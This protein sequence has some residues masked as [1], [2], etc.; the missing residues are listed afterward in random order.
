MVFQH[1]VEAF[2]YL[3][4]CSFSFLVKYTD[5]D[6]VGARGIPGPAVVVESQTTT[7]V[8]RGFEARAGMDGALEL[9]RPDD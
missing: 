4:K 5:I 8:P 3:R 9:L 6:Q 1:P 2:D 7:V